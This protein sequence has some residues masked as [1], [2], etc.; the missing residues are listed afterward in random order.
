MYTTSLGVVRATHSRC[1]LVRKILDTS[2]A[3]FEELDLFDPYVGKVH[4]TELKARMGACPAAT[5]PQVFLRGRWLAVSVNRCRHQSF[6][7]VVWRGF[8]AVL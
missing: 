1:A 3:D 2:M 8:A 6:R 4:Q 7:E 5:V